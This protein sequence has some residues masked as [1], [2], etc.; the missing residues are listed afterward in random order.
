MAAAGGVGGE[1]TAAAGGDPTAAAG[2]VSDETRAAAGGESGEAPAAAGHQSGE[3]TTAAAAGDSDEKT[4]AAGCGTIAAPGGETTAAA[5]GDTG[6]IADLTRPGALSKSLKDALQI[7]WNRQ[8]F[9]KEQMEE[10]RRCRSSDCDQLKWL[11]M[12]LD[13]KHL[14][15]AKQELQHHKEVQE[16]QE[17]GKQQQTKLLYAQRQL[18]DVEDVLQQQ[19]DVLQQQK[20]TLTYQDDQLTQLWDN[21]WQKSEQLERNLW[22]KSQELEQV[23]EEQRAMAQ[24]MEKVL[25]QRCRCFEQQQRERQQAVHP[26]PTEPLMPIRSTRDIDVNDPCDC[27]IIVRPTDQSIPG[28]GGPIDT[29]WLYRRCR[30]DTVR[31]PLEPTAPGT[32]VLENFMTTNRVQP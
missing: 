23:R 28:Q 4:A 18:Q 17:Q 29:E 13:Q 31:Q 3:T 6:T 21:L 7:L 20:E 16:L 26:S 30:N 32:P 9:L 24:T 19:E 25:E 14:Q 5:V 10:Y 15:M 1:M 27:D 12:Q 22:E 2:G 11:Q 8:Q